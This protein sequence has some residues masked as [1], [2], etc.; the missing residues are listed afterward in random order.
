MTE[1]TMRVDKWLWHARLF[2]S[3]TLASRLCQDGKIRIDGTVITKANQPVRPG[4]V[5]T[6]PQARTI[7]VVRVMALGDRRGSAREAQSLYEEIADTG[8]GRAVPLA[9]SRPSSTPSAG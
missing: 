1:T 2:K 5:L 9:A 8:A 4:S 7:R 6:F 3:R